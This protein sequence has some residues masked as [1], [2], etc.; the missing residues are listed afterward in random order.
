MKDAL[1]LAALQFLNWCLCTLSWRAVAH[2]DVPLAVVVDTTLATLQFCVIQRIART[3]G[4]WLLFTGYTLGS[5]TG[6]VAG[7]HLSIYI[8]GR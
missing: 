3:G 4:G 8:M 1:T 6:T 2:A 7:I 5:V